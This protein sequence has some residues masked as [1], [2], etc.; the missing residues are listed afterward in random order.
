MKTYALPLCL[1][2]LL[3]ACGDIQETSSDDLLEPGLSSDALTKAQD[4]NANGDTNFCDDP[5]APCVL[6]E[7]DCDA[8]ADCQGSLICAPDVGRRF[9]KNGNFDYCLADHCTN[10]VQDGNETD[11]DCG[12]DC[13]SCT[14]VGGNPGTIEFCRNVKCAEGQGNCASDS[15]CEDGLDCVQ[16]VGAQYGFDPSTDVCVLVHC[17]DGIQNEDE[18]GVDCGGSRCMACNNN[19]GGGNPDETL[20]SGSYCNSTTYQCAEGEGDCDSD[21]ECQPG[22]ECV[23]DRGANFPSFQPQNWRTDVCLQ[24][25][26]GNNVRDASLGETAVDCGGPCGTCPTTNPREPGSN[27][28]CSDPNFPCSDGQG[29][30]DS[31]AECQAGLNCTDNVGARYG[32]SSSTD[33]CTSASCTD[34]VIDGSVEEIGDG[35][36]NATCGP[37]D[38]ALWSTTI[39]N[40]DD[41]TVLATTTDT[42]GNVYVAGKFT[43]QLTLGGSTFNNSG[44]SSTHD[45]FV[46]KYDEDGE[47]I[48]STSF[49]G[50]ADEDIEDIA[51]DP[52][53]DVYL[54][55]SYRS[56]TMTIGATTLI[57]AGQSDIFAVK[58]N[59]VTSSPIWAR[60]IGS[61]GA[62]EGASA[63]ADN[64]GSVYVLGAFSGTVN[65]GAGNTLV[66]KGARDMV[67]MSLN[68]ATGATKWAKREGG[69]GNEFPEDL[70]L[71]PGNTLVYAVTSRSVKY[72]YDS[73]NKELV[74]QG[75][76]DVIIGKASR[77][78]GATAWVNI[79][80]GTGFDSIESVAVDTT[81][82]IYAT[83]YFYGS[84]RFGTNPITS[85]GLADVFLAKFNSSGT[86]IRSRGFGG[87]GF[88]SAES[89]SVA[90]G[91]LYITGYFQDAVD[92]GGPTV[93]AAGQ[94]D[95]FVAKIN[96]SSLNHVETQRYGGDVGN[97]FGRAFTSRNGVY[98]TGFYQEEIDL[99]EGF[100]TGGGNLNGF[101]IRLRP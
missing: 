31:D 63:V 43:V 47:F 77:S 9:G 27:A 7:G 11:I 35:C 79:Y 8:D 52:S 44:P 82:N 4:P 23:S 94:T 60:S 80:G 34:E 62:D 41:V 16:D 26:C 20:G 48:W 45:I 13:G 30:C 56:T 69:S 1:L 3:S 70:K 53:G 73:T 36:G 75:L 95:I 55:G 72:L 6:F 78:T 96:S 28:Y 58:L 84:V 97:S 100:R 38:F 39:T 89:I 14:P 81:G 98:L 51:V 93:E 33:V 5:S 22:L 83:G 46:A 91:I 92:F 37:C 90:N 57:N 10:D 86:H 99:G 29:D 50:N 67:L 40:A 17:S 12:G 101:I 59:G 19:G 76:S 54:V 74:S 68:S 25:H 85:N 18:T 71:S 32:F 42:D 21:A 24:P 87:E 49:G 88:D 2:V 15:E 65:F 64:T 66:T 61:T